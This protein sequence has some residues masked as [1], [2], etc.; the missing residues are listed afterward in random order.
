MTRV[1]DLINNELMPTSLNLKIVIGIV[2]FILLSAGV[3][4]LVGA[5]KNPAQNQAAK[6][7][8]QSSSPSKNSF[9]QTQTASLQGKITKVSE[10]GITVENDKKESKTFAASNK[11]AIYKFATNSTQATPSSDLKAIET[12]KNA[13][14]NLELVGNDYQ[15]LSIS[16]LPSVSP[17]PKKQ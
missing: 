10:S 5:K 2:I 4:Y 13:I 15:I 9:F 16:Y 7:S 8:D 6:T 12:G 14:L 3:G 11:L 1:F 17:P